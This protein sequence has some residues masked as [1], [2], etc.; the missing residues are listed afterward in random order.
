[1]AAA[2]K[3]AAKQPAA[4]T[5]TKAQAK[6]APRTS[7]I[8]AVTHVPGFEKH[9]KLLTAQALEVMRTYQPF[10]R[11]DGRNAVLGPLM[12]LSR[13]LRAYYVILDDHD[14]KTSPARRR[15]R[16]A[17]KEMQELLDRAENHEAYLEW[18]LAEPGSRRAS[19]ALKRY[20]AAYAEV[21]AKRAGLTVAQYKKQ[22]AA[23]E[24]KNKAEF[25]SAVNKVLTEIGAA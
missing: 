11:F 2:A 14:D 24:D 21:A 25:N 22:R 5:A 8:S 20:E 12:A 17:E 18:R 7:K 4:K 13:Y 6:A 10:G 9:M 16:K 3:K 1:M 19:A 15:S 23:I